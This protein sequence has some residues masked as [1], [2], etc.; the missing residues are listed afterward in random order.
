MTDKF[1]CAIIA[2]HSEILRKAVKF[3]ERDPVAQGIR[4]LITE[5]GMIQKVV[6][7]RAGFTQQQFNDML[8]NRKVI[9]AI[10]LVPISSALGVEVQ[11]IYDA[12]R[13]QGKEAV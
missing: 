5:K 2:L 12:G 9:R 7:Q 1:Y 8:N 10:D 4:I 13:G 6:A 11:D 3:L